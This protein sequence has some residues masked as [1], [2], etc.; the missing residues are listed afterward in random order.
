MEAEP[1]RED[2]DAVVP[3]RKRTLADTFEREQPLETRRGRKVK[4]VQKMSL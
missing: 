2:Q 4:K 1:E 3:S